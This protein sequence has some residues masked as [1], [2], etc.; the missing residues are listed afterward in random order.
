MSPTITTQTINFENN[1]TATAVFPTAKTTAKEI[2]DALKLPE[3][4]S[5]LLL[6]GG[7]DNL[8][9]KIKARLSQL[10]G[11][12]VARAALTVNAVIVDGGTQAGV[13]A[14]MG[15]GVAARGYKSSL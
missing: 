5:V 4:S 8:D 7:A 12:G 14:L 11:R 10:F 9:D 6:I 3:Y 13:M 2:V 1:R 15:E